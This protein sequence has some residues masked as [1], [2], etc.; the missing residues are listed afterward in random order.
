MLMASSRWSLQRGGVVAWMSGEVFVGLVLGFFLGL[1]L[2]P[3]IRAWLSWQEWKSAAREA[4]RAASRRRDLPVDEYD[5]VD[6]EA[7]P[8]LPSKDVDGHPLPSGR[9]DIR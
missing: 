9:R 6:F 5:G 7:W 3:V 8:S 4:D 2:G 1:V